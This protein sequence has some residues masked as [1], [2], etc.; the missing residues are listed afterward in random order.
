MGVALGVRL[1]VGLGLGLG[2]AL[3]TGVDD[4]GERDGAE[5]AGASAEQ[6]VTRSTAPA[7]AVTHL[8]RRPYVWCFL[9][10]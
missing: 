1:T 7:R 9:L 6:P 2:V 8:I 3:G 10:G 5:G 4:A